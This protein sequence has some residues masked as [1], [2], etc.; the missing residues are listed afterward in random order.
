MREPIVVGAF[1]EPFLH[2]YGGSRLP[3]RVLFTLEAQRPV[4]QRLARI[5]G[6]RATKGRH[7]PLKQKVNVLELRS[8]G[9]KPSLQAQGGDSPGDPVVFTFSGD[10]GLLLRNVPFGRL[11][12]QVG[13]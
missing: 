5:I 9:G 2:G 4:A 10:P 11:R 12:Y 7:A 6:G 13:R 1:P 3:A 8:P